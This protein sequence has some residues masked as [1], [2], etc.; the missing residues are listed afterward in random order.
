[1][2]DQPPEPS[3]RGTLG[4]RASR[5]A[6]ASVLG[7]GA[8]QGLRLVGNL[9]LSYLLF[10]EAFGLMLIANTVLLGLQILSDLGLAPAI[11][12]HPRGDDR[13]FVD[14][15]WTIGVVRGVVLFA[16]GL[17]LTIPIADFYR[18]PMLRQIIPAAASS[19][20]IVG[21]ISTKIAS[22]TRH[23]RP[24]PVLA[25][26]IAAQAAGLVAMIVHAKLAPS[27]WVLV[28]GGLVT[29]VVKTLLSQLALPGPM[30][31]FRWEA[32]ARRDLASFGKWLFVSSIFTF[33]AMR[34]DVVMLGR[35]L[36]VDTLG[37]YSIGIMLSMVVR[38]VLQ[39]IHRFSLMPAMA[40][41]HRAG[42][43]VLA[44]NF[45]RVRGLAL[46]AALLAILGA[47]LLAPAFFGLLYDERYHAAA[48]IAQLS[49]VAVWFS[50]L[51]DVNGHALL[52]AGNSRAWA[53]TNAVRAIV[54]TAGCALGFFLGGLPGLMIGG[55]FGTVAAYA[56]STIQLSGLGIS[57][58]RTDLPWTAIGLALGGIGAF[59]PY[60]TGAES[61]RGL[62]IR[63]LA[64]TVV[65]LVPFGA[66]VARRLLGARTAQS[67]T[68]WRLHQPSSTKSDQ[69]RD[70]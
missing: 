49:M 23:L 57:A 60:W 48:W 70:Q 6:V 39:Q 22:L 61:A 37:V 53:V 46:P 8:A 38:D 7:Q 2:N 41:S 5:A 44:D 54:T 3:P 26:E 15:A 59:T 19:A 64:A 63:S 51:A 28:V 18:E 25:V 21:L 33:V 50:F 55:L 4:S 42:A 1:M 67:E 24:G 65:L 32:R 12:R 56:V 34:S 62:A 47:T 20:L 66:W 30:N 68:P 17:L 11:I 69:G 43:G 31:R 52:A 16:I 27:V 35:L 10:P 40:A 9:I 13:D 14:T 36:P 45:A 29:A 58:V